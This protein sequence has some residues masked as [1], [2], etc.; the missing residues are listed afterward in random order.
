MSE[1]QSSYD[2]PSG[3]AVGW[4]AFAAIMLI[5]I[6]TF[7]AIAGLAGILENE[8]YSAVPAAGTEAAGDVYFLQFDATTWGWIH[9]LG[10]IIVLLA[11]LALFRG[12]VWARTIGVI[13]AVI[14]AIVNFAWL[15]WYPVWSITMIAIAL[16][17]I[18]ALTAHGR[19]IVVE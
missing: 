9:L 4:I 14:S 2:E 19:D 6:G 8:F 10:G 13:V 18:W 7:H 16:A 12:A 3:A 1:R 11:G 15:P 17:V 5:M